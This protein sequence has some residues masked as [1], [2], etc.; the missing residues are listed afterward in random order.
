MAFEKII[1][2]RRCHICGAM[3]HK[4]DGPVDRCE[5]CQKAFAPFCFFDERSMDGV[6]VDQT[7][8]PS[9][10][11]HSQD[12]AY[13]AFPQRPADP[14]YPTNPNNPNRTHHPKGPMFTLSKVEL[15]QRPVKT[16]VTGIRPIYG[17]TSYW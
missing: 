2:F 9:T 6:N 17:L 8:A 4:V 14:K 15:M 1:H 5:N 7:P 11:E 3:N 13:P 10:L 16:A 12:P